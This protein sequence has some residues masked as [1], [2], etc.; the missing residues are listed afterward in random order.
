[1]LSALE[2]Q[3]FVAGA[4]PLLIISLIW[5][6]K[7]GAD[8]LRRKYLIWFEDDGNKLKRMLARSI[9]ILWVGSAFTSAIWPEEPVGMIALY[10][11]IATF[12][13]LPVSKSESRFLSLYQKIVTIYIIVVLGALG[14]FFYIT[15]VYPKIP[16]EFGGVL[17]RIAR[18]D[19]AIDTT[20]KETFQEILSVNDTDINNQVL[21]SRSVDVY[22]SSGN[23][24]L[25]KAH[26]QKGRDTPTY[27]IQRDSIKAIVW[28]R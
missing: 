9:D 6:A 21:R 19:I 24:L 18:L 22:F 26:G 10:V 16:Q 15:L 20:S 4:I 13:L 27:E 8:I 5:W 25:V 14:V 28:S 23:T 1:M 2:A 12:M 7:Q 11:F 17:P 3:Y